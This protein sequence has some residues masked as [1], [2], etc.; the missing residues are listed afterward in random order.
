MIPAK[1]EHLCNECRPTHEEGGFSIIMC[2]KCGSY[3]LASSLIL[4]S[5][6][7]IEKKQCSVMVKRN[8]QLNKEPVDLHTGN[9]EQISESYRLYS[10]PDK[11][12]NIL[13][14]IAEQSEKNGLGT[15][16]K[17]DFE[18]DKYIAPVLT[19][20]ELVFLVEI[21]VTE[22]Y[23]E[24]RSQLRGR[25]LEPTYLESLRV[26]YKGWEKVLDSTGHINKDHCFVAMPFGDSE[27]Q[28]NV[29][30]CIRDTINDFGFKTIVENRELHN[31]DIVLDII[32][33]IKTCRFVIA[34][35]KDQ[36]AN[37][38][39]EAGYARGLGRPVIWHCN[40]SE[41]NK[42]SK[43]AFD[44]RNLNHI[45]WNDTED[46]RNQLMLRINATIL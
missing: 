44:T 5:K 36:R 40:K 41:V 25:K 19:N 43:N 10:L 3:K 7:E 27:Y 37:V 35:A 42:L 18:K 21:L 46:L 4:S 31:D 14:Y 28:N 11:T 30:D 17:I 23:L 13:K 38:F 6:S 12:N 24:V 45:V 9:F 16:V 20:T 15:Y 29:M 33:K 34:D 1:N 26:S 22:G 8:Y 39:Y 2:E 32:G